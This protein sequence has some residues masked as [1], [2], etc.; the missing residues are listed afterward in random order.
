MDPRNHIGAKSGLEG[1]FPEFKALTEFRERIEREFFC[2]PGPRKAYFELPSSFIDAKGDTHVVRLVY[3]TIAYVS[4][5]PLNEDTV[6]T[7]CTKAWDEVFQPVLDRYK[8][9]HDGDDCRDDRMLFWRR[10][11]VVGPQNDGFVTLRMRCVVPGTQ[12]VAY[13]RLA[14]AA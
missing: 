3:E 6:Q 5:D 10:E 11:P 1:N 7:L 13:N 2:V 14:S 8:A 4:A 9:Y 12:L